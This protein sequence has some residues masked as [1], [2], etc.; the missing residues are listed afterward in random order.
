MYFLYEKI[1][2]YHQ[3]IFIITPVTIVTLTVIRVEYHIISVLSWYE[4]ETMKNEFHTGSL[5]TCIITKKKVGT[6][7]STHM[8]K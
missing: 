3:H 4:L 1:T 2:A 8:A 5:A 6:Q 7:L